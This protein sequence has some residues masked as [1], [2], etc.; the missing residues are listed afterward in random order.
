[1]WKESYC[2]K[3]ELFAIVVLKCCLVDNEC[4]SSRREMTSGV[5]GLPSSKLING[6]KMSVTMLA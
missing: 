1:M 2:V 6:V 3:A 4:C 5:T